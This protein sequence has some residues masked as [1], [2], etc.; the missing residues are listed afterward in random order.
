MPAETPAQHFARI[1][2][3]TAERKA[4]AEVEGTPPKAERV[5]PRVAARLAAETE[6]AR[7][8]IGGNGAPPL[9]PKPRPQM[10]RRWR[11]SMLSMSMYGERFGGEMAHAMDVSA[12][13]MRRWMNEGDAIPDYAMANARAAGEAQI[14]AIQA[15]LDRLDDLPP[16]GKPAAPAVA[17]PAPAALVD[18]PPAKPAAPARVVD[19]RQVD[20]E[21][22]IA[23]LG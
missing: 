3:L 20:L 22:Y 12:R 14:R 18:E 16:G 5:L 19:P 10:S 15:A 23:S 11:L 1:A 4:A 6:A 8:G 9:E 13:T 21:A 7:H 17:D 2:K